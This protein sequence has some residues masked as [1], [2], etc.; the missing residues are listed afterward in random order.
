MNANKYFSIEET[1][2][3]LIAFIFII[4]S[5]TKL[6]DVAKLK[7]YSNDPLVYFYEYGKKNDCLKC[8]HKFNESISVNANEKEVDI[9]LLSVYIIR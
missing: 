6:L 8:R 1:F 2:A 7:T 9:F 5:F 4:E 3:S